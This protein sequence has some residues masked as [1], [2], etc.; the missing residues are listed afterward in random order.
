MDFIN[1][2]LNLIRENIVDGFN[3]LLPEN[4]ITNFVLGSG[5]MI[6]S[7]V[8]LLYFLSQGVLLNDKFYKMLS[9]VEIL[10][11]AS[12]LHDDV[13]DDAPTRR[14][15]STIAKDFSDKVSILVGDYLIL[16]AFEKIENSCDEIKNIFKEYS[17]NIIET[18]IKQFFARGK[19]IST[20][21]YIQICKGKT[22]SLFILPLYVGAIDFI[23]DTNS[24]KKF[25]E[26]F[27]I[28]FQIKNDLEKFSAEVDAKNRL[29]T[30]KD[31]LGIEKT[32]LLL[33]NYR[34]EMMGIIK[35]FPNNIYK[36]KLEDLIKDL[37]T[38]E[39]S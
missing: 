11:N 10:H 12:L 35:D 20:E 19:F 32:L 23:K 2:E 39:R 24:A 3:E 21:E 16:F 28:A 18:E 37:C 13:I 15:K 38:I 26:M 30:A 8:S 4:S 31:I 14:G 5:K 25:G 9:A 22:A 7:K 17:R 6:R 1:L 33:D 29:Y 34:E 36:K 27:G